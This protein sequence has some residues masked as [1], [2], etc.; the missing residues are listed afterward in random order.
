MEHLSGRN[1]GKFG[2]DENL[3]IKLIRPSFK[4]QCGGLAY[5][6]ASLYGM[7]HIH[8]TPYGITGQCAVCG[9]WATEK[10]HAAP[11]GNGGGMRYLTVQTDHGPLKLESAL[12]ALCHECHDKFPPQGTEYAVKWV[13]KDQRSADLWWSGTLFR[14]GVEPHSDDLYEYGFYAFSAHGKVIGGVFG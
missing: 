11:K 1:K 2:L 12:I 4:I 10:H 3:E 7:P 8:C 13:W 9:R 6:R 14:M 5:D